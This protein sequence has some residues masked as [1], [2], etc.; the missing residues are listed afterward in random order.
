MITP[1]QVSLYK[2]GVLW[3]LGD[4]GA[5]IETGRRLY[6]G[7]FPTPER[8]ARLHTDMARAWWQRGKPD[9]TA[10]ALLAAYDQVSAEVSTRPAIRKMA[11]DLVRQHPRATGVQELATAIGAGR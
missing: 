11:T 6:P 9:E 8:R 1:A 10:L 5:A 7:Q 4:A 2:V 3:S